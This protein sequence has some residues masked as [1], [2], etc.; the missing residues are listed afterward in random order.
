MEGAVGLEEGPGA[1][2]GYVGVDQVDDVGLIEDELDGLLGDVSHG[3]KIEHGT[4]KV[5]DRTDQR[6]WNFD[7]M[8]SVPTAFGPERRFS[9]MVTNDLNTNSVIQFLEKNVK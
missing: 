7:G 6:M 5:Q 9:G 3:G 4:S 8:S 1:L 2:E